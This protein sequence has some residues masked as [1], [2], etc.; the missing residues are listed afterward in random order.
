MTRRAFSNFTVWHV[1]FETICPRDTINCKGNGVRIAKEADTAK[2][3]VELPYINHCILEIDVRRARIFTFSGS[4]VPIF[5]RVKGG[6]IGMSNVA[7]LLI[8][9]GEEINLSTY[10]VAQQIRGSNFPQP[11]IFLDILLLEASSTYLV[12]TEGIKY[13]STILKPI[14]GIRKQD[15]EAYLTNVFEGYFKA[16]LPVAVPLSAGYDSRL[17]LAYAVHFAKKY[18][19]QIRAYHEFK[20]NQ[21]HDIAQR[22]A[23]EANIPFICKSRTCFVDKF[24]ELIY[25]PEFILFHSGTYRDNLLRWHWYIRWMQA[26]ASDC[27]VIGFGAEAHKGKYYRKIHNLFNDSEK[28][29]GINGDAI[30][31]IAAFM[32]FY[33]YDRTKQKLFFNELC[34]HAQIYD[35][36]YSQ[37]D[38]LHYHTYI[39]GYYH[40]AHYLLQAFGMPFPLLE[41]KF[42][43]AVFSLNYKKKIDFKLV[44]DSIHKLAPDLYNITFLSGNRKAL[45]KRT[46]ISTF[47]DPVMAKLRRYTHSSLS[48]KERDQFLGSSDIKR[49]SD[50]GFDSEITSVL[51]DI[52]LKECKTTPGIRLIYAIQMFLY[53]RQIEKD[54]S[55]TFRCA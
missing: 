2:V 5:A 26:T 14:D 48:P 44:K 13:E 19:N 15:I 50:A 21:E 35:N 23:K 16:G 38:F 22:V 40:R 37:I 52:I 36:L 11:N 39:V 18:N 51:H 31:K 45:A 42:L 1:E 53:L 12:T 3:Y 55:V 28:V 47:T 4:K 33:D 30:N 7:Y 49:I 32:G 27:I 20:N 9:E 43:Q 29:L 41:D 24:R 8:D 54:L 25:D 34:E 46:I 17:N 10:V 6:K